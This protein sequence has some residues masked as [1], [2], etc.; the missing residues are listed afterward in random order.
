MTEQKKQEGAFWNNWKGTAIPATGATISNPNASGAYSGFKGGQ[1]TSVAVDPFVADLM[2]MNPDEIF[3]V[4]TLLKNSNYLRN[5]TRRYNKTLGDA[6]SRAS[7]DWS[8]ESARTGRPT[9]TFREFLIE[10]F[11]PSGAGAGPA[12]PSRQVYAVTPEQIENDINEI[13]VAKGGRTITDADKQADWYRDLVRGINKLYSRGIV[14]EVKK[15]KNPKTGKMERVV[16]QTPGF[17]EEKIS[18]K[19]T[20]AFEQADPASIE[21]KQNIEFA[22][23]AFQKMGGRG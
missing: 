23:W 12:L 4:S 2:R 17:S 8:N 21:R 5:T 20:T 13:V 15:V 1:T 10:N 18:E 19:I 3:Q 6:Y 7:M 22:N 9:L 16:T 11:S 14:T